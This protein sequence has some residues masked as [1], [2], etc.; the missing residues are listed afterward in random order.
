[1]APAQDSLSRSRKHIDHQWTPGDIS[2][3]RRITRRVTAGSVDRK[4]PHSSLQ[5]HTESPRR[6]ARRRNVT[7]ID[8]RVQRKYLPR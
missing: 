8:T 6:K 1:M 7:S 5:F 4:I 3:G 2:D